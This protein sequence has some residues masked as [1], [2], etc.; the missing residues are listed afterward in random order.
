MTGKMQKRLSVT[1]QDHADLKPHHIDLLCL[2]CGKGDRMTILRT[3]LKSLIAV[4]GKMDAEGVS[5]EKLEMKDKLLDI[6]ASCTEV[7]V[8]IDLSIL[9]QK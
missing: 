1:S 5:Q 2:M 4:Y 3:C 7:R 8:Q 9:S 6:L